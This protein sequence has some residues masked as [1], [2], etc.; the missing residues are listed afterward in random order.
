MTNDT[1]NSEVFNCTQL[2]EYWQTFTRSK[3]YEYVLLLILILNSVTAVFVACSNFLVI[4]VIAMTR[5]LHS[6]SYVIIL[7]LA[8]SDLS[9]GVLSQPS[10]SAIQYYELIE[11]S[12][13]YCVAAVVYQ[14]SGWA[15]A[16]ISLLTLTALTADRFIA[17][18]I[19]LRYKQLVTC[20]R[21]IVVL[22][23][24]WIYGTLGGVFRLST[25]D[26]VFRNYIIIL[27]IACALN[28]IFLCLINRTVR[29]HS[30]QI[31]ALHAGANHAMNIRMKKSVNVMYYVIGTFVVC[32]CPY[33]SCLLA[34]AIIKDWTQTIRIF[35][36]I[37]EYFVLLNSLLNPVIYCWRIQ[38]IRSATRQ[39]LREIFNKMQHV[40]Q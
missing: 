38:E 19:H 40:H 24:I 23:L 13:P 7:G 34:V 37:G 27:T 8:I 36:R 5:S 9:V 20:Q 4:Y 25:T 3:V 21:T 30:A 26:D 32:Y 29:R 33:I 12:E 39:R 6:P 11:R 18:H 22:V 16:S 28:L 2:P 35:F 31:N 17:L 1:L 14:F 15:L 10:F